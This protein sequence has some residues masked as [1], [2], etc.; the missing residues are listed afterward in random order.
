MIVVKVEL[1]SAK[2]G[3]TTLLGAAT[4][5]NEGTVTAKT[6]GRR[7]NYYCRF[8]GKRKGTLPWRTSDVIGFP[9]KSLNAWHLLHRALT[10]ALKEKA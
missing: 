9:R 6:N 2:T 8:W 10:E 4:I 3:L 1:V 5:T 7:G